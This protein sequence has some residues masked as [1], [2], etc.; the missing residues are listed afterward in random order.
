[1]LE[2]MAQPLGRTFHGK[3]WSKPTEFNSDILIGCL[4]CRK[5]KVRCR[6]GGDPC[7]NCSRMNLDCHGSFDEN[8]R[9][10]FG[11]SS[12]Q[13]KK[14]RN[15]PKPRSRLRSARSST[16]RSYDT[17][18]QQTDIQ[19]N[20]V[21]VR[22]Q[23]EPD[24][25]TIRDDSEFSAS[26]PAALL[27]QSLP[28]NGINGFFSQDTLSHG[29]YTDPGSF[30]VNGA[31]GLDFG[32]GGF[33]DLWDLD[34]G[35]TGLTPDDMACNNVPQFMSSNDHGTV[36]RKG[37]RD[38]QWNNADHG[39]SREIPFVNRDDDFYLEHYERCIG[40][41]PYSIKDDGKGNYLRFMLDF[42][43]SR[44]CDD[45]SPFRLSLLAWAAKHFQV[46]VQA[47]DTNWSRYYHRAVDS[48]AALSGQNSPGVM[49][50]PIGTS[51]M[52]SPADIIICSTLILCRCDTL[53][54]NLAS[55][56]SHLDDLKSQI[57]E[58]LAGSSLSPFASQ[59]LLWLGYLHVRISLF[60]QLPVDNGAVS[61]TL[62]DAIIDHPDYKQICARSHFYLSATIGSSYPQDERVQEVEKLPVSTRTHETF[63]LL[64]S[65]IRF[66][67]WRNLSGD[68]SNMADKNELEA[69]KTTAIELDIR[70]IE[71]EFALAAATNA[72]ASVMSL[73]LTRPPPPIAFDR[74]AG[75]DQSGL[76]S[77]N[78]ARATK[79]TEPAIT[80]ASLQWLSCYTV[81]LATKILWSRIC[82]PDI[83]S[84]QATQDTVASILRIVLH[85][86]QSLEAK[87]SSTSKW[88]KV[89]RT[90]AWPL[91]L[92]IAG[93]E[94]TDE[95]HAD[96]TRR[97]MDDVSSWENDM[98]R[99]TGSE[100]NS[101]GGWIGNVSESKRVQAL[102]I[103]TRAAQAARGR[104]VDI[105]SIMD[106][107]SNGN[108]A[109][110]I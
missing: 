3:H 12:G 69:A 105:G 42:V 37:P 82:S 20:R 76:P 39:S 22:E 98:M 8:L 61:T 55:I 73:G 43:R 45:D 56:R 6:G 71:A 90:M 36:S 74:T 47:D 72:S 30:D 70:R 5:R 102:M 24:S 10:S 84:D 100:K 1:M 29:E 13:S 75:A 31:W 64:S 25:A 23:R 59:A 48:R 104:R 15:Q 95:I 17:A 87:Q 78:E 103:Q 92:F 65:M 38:S 53:N 32:L 58:Y 46:A 41:S 18:A 52:S 89:P 49:S 11:G 62:L 85:M 66:R 50:H 14:E 81:F 63:L 16:S 4:T 44:E 88:F 101:S 28:S 57:G 40:S 60:S 51:I 110:L 67:S 91:P 80:R 97:F 79:Q 94:T 9:I 108:G 83:R 21:A 35:A 19:Q 34:L 2:L 54:D 7:Q 109:F 96:W 99:S 106:E 26:Q 93:I 68:S 86:R 27:P 77:V 33:G 107:M